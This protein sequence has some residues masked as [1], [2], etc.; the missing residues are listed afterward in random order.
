[1]WELGAGSEQRRGPAHLRMSVPGGCRGWWASGPSP[2]SPGD[3]GV[4]EGR[5]RAAGDRTR[6]RLA[7]LPA[8]GASRPRNARPSLTSAPRL[9]GLPLWTRRQSRSAPRRFAPALARLGPGSGSGGCAPRAGPLGQAA[10]HHGPRPGSRPGSH[11]P[12][13]RARDRDSG[14]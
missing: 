2:G 3:P 10:A 12:A 9:L 8:G 14:R 4:G 13:L 1:M 6:Q 7:R 5:V 11:L